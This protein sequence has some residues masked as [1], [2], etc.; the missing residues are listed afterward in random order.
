MRIYVLQCF[1]DIEPHFGI[2]VSDP[3]SAIPEDIRIDGGNPVT[4]HKG[5]DTLGLQPT[6]YTDAFGRDVKP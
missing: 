4:K 6:G 1:F 2:A 5:V 3:E